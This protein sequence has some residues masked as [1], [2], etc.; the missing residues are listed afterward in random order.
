MQAAAQRPGIGYGELAG[1]P[2]WAA[3]QG[4]PSSKSTQCLNDQAM[5][6]KLIQASTD[7]TTQYPNFGGT[8]TFILNGKMLDDRTWDKLEPAIRDALGS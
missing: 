1:L 3:Q 6:A 5:I 7:A 8:P 2:Q 4:V